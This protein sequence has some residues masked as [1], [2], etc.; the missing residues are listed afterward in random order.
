MGL[1]RKMKKNSMKNNVLQIRQRN[2]TMLVA[3]EVKRHMENDW[4]P[5]V[6]AGAMGNL[7]IMILAF[8]HI[9][10]HHTGQFILKWL[11]EFNEFGDAVNREGQAGIEGLKQIL[12]D[13]CGID[14][15]D[16]F[17][18]LRKESEARKIS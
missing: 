16:V 13:E 4:E 9:D 10:R 14:V 17:E 3:D 6:Q 8:L 15:G 18:E 2:Q 1:T 12:K 11:R 7:M 5:K